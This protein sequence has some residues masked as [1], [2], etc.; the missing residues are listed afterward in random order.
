MIPGFNKACKDHHQKMAG[1]GF[2]KARTE[3][4]NV[5]FITQQIMLLVTEASE[6][7]EALREDNRG[8]HKDSFEDE[9][10]DVTLRLMDLIGGL[11]I[12]IEQ[13]LERKSAYNAT[14]PYLHGK[15]F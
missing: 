12:D 5:M 1:K 15:G 4:N 3:E 13:H 14:R 8:A 11:D 2:W 6:A 7:V 9:I 10:A